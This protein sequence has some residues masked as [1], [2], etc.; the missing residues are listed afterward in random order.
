MFPAPTTSAISTPRL[1][2]PCTWA[3]IPSTRSG[4]VPY[5]RP[6]IRASPES[7]SS[8]RLNAGSSATAQTSYAL[9]P[10]HKPGEARDPHVLAGPRRDLRTQFLDRLALV[11]VGANV[12]LLEKRDLLRPLLKLPI[13]DL[14]NDV[15]RLALLA[16]LGLE[17]PALSLPSLV[18]D[19]VRGHHRGR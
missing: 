1:A 16:S 15:V 12:L 14:S 19:L 17:D 3:A 4:S 2:T 7:F 5:S 6:P 13:D 11:G 18:W 8:T 9:F 10:D